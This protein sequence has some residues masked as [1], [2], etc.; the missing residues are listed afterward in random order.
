M[1]AQEPAVPGG[2]AQQAAEHIAPP[3]VGGQDAVGNHK[4]RGPNVVRYDPQ[5]HIRP[6]TLAISGARQCRDPV[7]DVHHR[8]H[9]KKTVHILTNHSQPL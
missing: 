9:I 5:R 2:P 6:V 8:V 4:G 7:G 1:D 3:L